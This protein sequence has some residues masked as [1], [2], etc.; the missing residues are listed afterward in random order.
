MPLIFC[1]ICGFLAQAK[2]LFF[3]PEN[4]HEVSNPDRGIAAFLRTPVTNLD[5]VGVAALLQGPFPA[6]VGHIMQPDAG[7]IGVI[8]TVATLPFLVAQRMIF[9]TS[10]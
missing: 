1:S 2:K 8:G 5:H 10:P 9:N 3:Y 7:G 4:A 6:P